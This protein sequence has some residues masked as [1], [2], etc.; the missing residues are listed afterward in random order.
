MGLIGEGSGTVLQG[1]RKLTNSSTYEKPIYSKKVYDISA[2]VA[3]LI[4]LM[5]RM[6]NVETIP[7]SSFKVLKTDKHPLIVTCNTNT[8]AAESPITVHSG[9]ASRIRAGDILQ[10]P[11]TKTEVRVLVVNTA[12]DTFTCTRPCGSTT[13]AAFVVDD[14]LQIIG[15]SQ[16]EFS[17]APESITTDIGSDTNY[18]QT[19]RAAVEASRRILNTE[20]YGGD[21][22]DR[23]I[24]QALEHMRILEEKQ[25]LFGRG[26]SASDPTITKGAM[27]FISTNVFNVGG[28][29]TEDYIR[30]TMLPQI[31]RRNDSV[32]ELA[33]FA[34]EKLRIAFSGFGVDSVRYTP[35]TKL[36]GVNAGAYQ[37][38][39]GRLTLIPHG[40]MT[41]LGSAVTAA[42]Y[43][44]QG[45]AI[46]LNL[47]YV[48]KR[49]MKGGAMRFGEVV[50]TNGPDGKKWGWLEDCGFW[51]ANEPMH[52]Y[53]DGI[54]G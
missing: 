18:C 34:G 47:K 22:V 8:N 38:P 1:Q 40:A 32:D 27:G 13:D 25:F 45:M 48:G 9:Q 23:N 20:Y 4:V 31:Y 52:G 37:S 30:E 17:T 19:F 39:F 26:Y 49:V 50:I 21:P 46:F 12:A 51:L 54:T 33:C 42:N 10:N 53:A 11:R 24:Q 5:E 35:D 3:K 41:P 15:N 44:Y 29:I 28:V 36:L 14:E 2:D 6:G 43:G 16:P 7:G